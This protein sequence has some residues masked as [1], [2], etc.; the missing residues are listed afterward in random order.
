MLAVTACLTE[1]QSILWD[2]TL[3]PDNLSQ[4]FS[5]L[6]MYGFCSVRWTPRLCQR[7]LDLAPTG[8]G[9]VLVID[10]NGHLFL[11]KVFMVK[12]NDMRIQLL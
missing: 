1:G 8:Q 2:E 10:F 5:L 4:P 3:M 7:V 6:Q 12:C 11:M 9:H